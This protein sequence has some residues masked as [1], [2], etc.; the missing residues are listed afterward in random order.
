M[1][2]GIA[3]RESASQKM[4]KQLVL[5]SVT[6]AGVLA[7]LAL[8]LIVLGAGKLPTPPPVEPEG[9][10]GQVPAA[11]TSGLRPQTF[12]EKTLPL[13]EV[14]SGDIIFRRGLSLESRVI[15]ALDGQ[16]GYSHAG[17]IRK[18]GMSVEI[19]HASFAEEGQ[20][21]ETII[22]E[23][24]TRFL[25]PSSSKAAAVYRFD[26]PDKT[27][28]L[29]ALSEAEQLL[30]ARVSFDKDFDLTTADKIYCTE[31]IWLSYKKAGI[32]LTAGR[33]DRVPSFL[34]DEKRDYILPSSL[35]NNSSL[36]K[37]WESQ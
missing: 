7:L 36:R 34:G 26:G 24:I 9:A 16:F 31:L 8:A 21:Q 5:I 18:N 20:T 4:R 25:K 3:A 30:K 12:L 11:E 14:E 13:N 32:D 33:F 23:P 19:I 35:L 27:L 22:S 2:P 6:C 1:R 28:P 10:A 29:T 17:I 15:M 37:V